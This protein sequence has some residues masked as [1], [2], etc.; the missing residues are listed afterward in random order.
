MLWSQFIDTET[1]APEADP[2]G[3]L[4]SYLAYGIHLLYK[5]SSE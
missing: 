2:P 3:H 1:K 5:M 4:L